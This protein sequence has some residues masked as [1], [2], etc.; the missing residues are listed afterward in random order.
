[1][2]TGPLLLTLL[3]SASQQ[4]LQGVLSM[5]PLSLLPV[6]LANGRCWQDTERQEEETRETKAKISYWDLIKIKRKENNS[7]TKRQ[8]TEWEKI[9]TNDILDNRL[10]SKIYKEL[11]RL[12]T[13]KTNNLVKKWAKDMN[14]FP[15]RHMKRC[16][17]SLII[18]VRN[19]NQNHNETP[20]HTCQNG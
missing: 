13:K 11:I 14:I 2:P 12:N 17:T 8:L 7:K 16:S 4:K 5:L 9:F 3:C 20:P 6:A 18:R 15:N 1:M 19:I 10:V